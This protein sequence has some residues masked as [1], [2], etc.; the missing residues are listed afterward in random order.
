M[1]TEA[2]S[3][4]VRYVLITVPAQYA[5]SVC[6]RM[7]ENGILAILNFAPVHL[8]VPEGILVQDEN[9]ATALAI[10][11]GHLKEKLHAGSEPA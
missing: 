6:D 7:I 10:L 5:Q 1:L 9:M 3:N 2:L 8:E 4:T 11:S